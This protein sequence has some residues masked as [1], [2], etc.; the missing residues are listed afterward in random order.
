MLAYALEWHRRQR[1]A[2][3]LLDGHDRAPAQ[4][5]RTSPVAKAPVS[6]AAKR[7][8]KSKRTE[9]GLPV[10]SFRSLLADLAT[11]TRNQVRFGAGDTF[12]MLATPTEVPRRSCDRLGV[13]LASGT[14]S[15]RSRAL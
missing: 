10:H 13:L 1:L 2:P 6:A 7:K 4:A 15:R 12:A 9:D 8:A 14:A 11:L 3:I 5:Q